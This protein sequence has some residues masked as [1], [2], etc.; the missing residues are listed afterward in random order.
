MPS[1]LGPLR[2]FGDYARL[3]LDTTYLI[4]FCLFNAVFFAW[5]AFIVYVLE[6]Y[7][8]EL[9]PTFTAA[10]DSLAFLSAFV[11]MPYLN[12]TLTGYNTE[13]V[14]YRAYL[15]QLNTVTMVCAKAVVD[16][17]AP[18]LVVLVDHGDHL[19]RRHPSQRPFTAGCQ[20][21]VEA[22]LR[23]AIEYAPFDEG[24]RV[25]VAR[26]KNEL[27]NDGAGDAAAN[28]V[29]DLLQAWSSR[30]KIKEPPYMK[31]HIFIFL[32]VWYGL[33]LP[34]VLW[35]RAGWMR[36]VLI[37]QFVSYVLWG[38]T[39][40]RFWLGSVWDICRPTRADAAHHTAHELWADE[41]KDAIRETAKLRGGG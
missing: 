36:A 16:K 22:G 29:F 18:Y 26:L 25:L 31:S 15:D 41:T 19:R 10:L 37:F 24:T 5:A 2:F 6:V 12:E 30:E 1:L 13:A 3:V 38:T 4:W 21:P 33:W 9:D 20:D 7:F 34:V 32:F 8:P 14:A 27:V 39:I 11:Y 23:K 17:I 35:R 28:R 40:L